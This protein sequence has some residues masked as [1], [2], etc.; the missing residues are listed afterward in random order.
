MTEE[1]PLDHKEL[2][3]KRATGTLRRFAYA[4]LVG[5]S[6]SIN[7]YSSGIRAS[8]TRLRSLNA[9]SVKIVESGVCESDLSIHIDFC[10]FMSVLA[11]ACIGTGP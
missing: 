11:T 10:S 5:G 6:N 2:A 9:Q 3:E 1:L 7:E 4:W 8:I